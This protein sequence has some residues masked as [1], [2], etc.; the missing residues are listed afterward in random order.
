MCE[1]L[2]FKGAPNSSF[3]VRVPCF[4]WGHQQILKCVSAL[5]SK[6]P[7]VATLICK[8]LAFRAASNSN[9]NVQVTYFQREPKQQLQCASTM[10][11]KGPPTATVMCKYR[12]FKATHHHLQWTNTESFKPL[13][14]LKKLWVKISSKKFWKDPTKLE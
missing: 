3:N 1:Y 13:R 5:L 7:P 14:N 10:L 9:C 12:P 2:A 6:G 8:Y 11:S 4:H